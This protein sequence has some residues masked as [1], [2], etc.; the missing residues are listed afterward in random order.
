MPS[1]AD[2]IFASC[3]VNC[4]KMAPFFFRLVSLIKRA[5]ALNVYLVLFIF[6]L[7]K[8]YTEK[9]FSHDKVRAKLFKSANIVLYIDHKPLLYWAVHIG[10]FLSRMMRGG[11]GFSLV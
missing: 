3:N 1:R 8:I 7:L 9:E 6:S 10:T 11:L 5:C 2:F 4:F